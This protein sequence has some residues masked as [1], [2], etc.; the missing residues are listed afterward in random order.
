MSLGADPAL[1]LGTPATIGWQFF[2]S[3]IDNDTNW[4]YTRISYSDV[5]FADTINPGSANV[6]DFMQ[7]VDTMSEV[8]R[9]SCITAKQTT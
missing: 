9:S 6:D 8:A 5:K 2:R 4:D 7:L 3:W 1:L